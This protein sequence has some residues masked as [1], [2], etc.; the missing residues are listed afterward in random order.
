MYALLHKAK[1]LRLPFDIVLE[2]YEHCVIPVLLYGSEVWGFENLH[3]L[4]VFH[5]QFL[6]LMLKTFKFTPN[7]MIYGETNTVD[8]RTKVD[9]RMVN[10][11][12]KLK[13]SKV[14]IS[15]IMNALLNKTYDDENDQKLR[16]PAKMKKYSYRG[17]FFPSMASTGCRL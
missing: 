12:L 2:L 1:I 15:V 8:I 11:W 16:W 14:K 10:F 5:R 6:K 13:S 9:I 7:C 17:S 3:R 4:E